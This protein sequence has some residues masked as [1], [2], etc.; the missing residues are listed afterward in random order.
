MSFHQ[1]KGIQRAYKKKI[2][3]LLNCNGQQFIER[4][5][6]TLQD[7]RITV[8]W[9]CCFLMQCFL[10]CIKYKFLITLIAMTSVYFCYDFCI[11]PCTE[12]TQRGMKQCRRENKRVLTCFTFEVSA[13]CTNHVL[14]NYCYLIMCFTIYAFKRVDKA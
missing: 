9:M 11:P 13:L 4:L 6:P 8:M 1:R 14:Q 7:Q 3:A 10:S 5:E 2:L 12:L